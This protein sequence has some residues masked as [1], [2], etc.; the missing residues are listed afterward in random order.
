M[1]HE[2]KEAI[3]NRGEQVLMNTYKRGDK[4]MTEGKQAYIK[5]IDG[6]EYLDFISGIATNVLGH[7]DSGFVEALKQQADKLIHTSNLFWNVPS[8]ELAELI[9]KWS[10]LD[11]V[12]FANSGAEANEGAIK[13]ARKWGRENKGD[14]AYEIIS[15]KES[16]HGRTLATLTA[17]GQ[18]EMHQPFKPT[19][20]GFRYV[21]FN[22]SAALEAAVNENTAALIFE[23]I[24]GEGG[25]NI[26]SDEF[27]QTINRIQADKN[28]LVIIDEIQTGIGRT[29]NMFAFQATDL[30]PDIITLA[31]GL[32][33]GIPI[34]AMVASDKT[35]KHFGPGDHGTTFGGNPF[36]AAAGLYILKTIEEQNL[37]DN[38]LKQS[39]RLREKLEQ[40]KDKY[41]SIKE[42]RGKG[43]LMGLELTVPVQEVV[44][45]AYENGLLVTSSKHNV[46]RILPPLN[47]TSEQ[48]N[49]CEQ[50]LNDVFSALV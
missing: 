39:N 34:G 27:I 7:A 8:I 28:V 44:D 16:F 21:P 37:L 18:E 43:L 29:G 20:P 2:T 48:I 12:F 26:I 41:A 24:Q 13:L 14:E 15:M 42:V 30:Q 50:I 36:A 22:D 17:T 49:Q 6:K 46:L 38:V 10:V 40:L 33:G 35:A 45:K 3:I 19:M 1:N 32:G 31:K 23:V 4:V 5:D 47:V 9:V 25:I 11:K